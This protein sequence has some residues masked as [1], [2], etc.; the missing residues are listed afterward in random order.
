MTLQ[1]GVVIILLL[2]MGVPLGAYNMFKLFGTTGTFTYVI[3]YGLGNIAA[4]R[5]FRTTGRDESSLIKYVLFPV[6]ATAALL[7][8]RLQV[9]HTASCRTGSLRP[10]NPRRLSRSRSDMPALGTAAWAAGVDCARW[11]HGDSC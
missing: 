5:Y 1:F 6:V 11:R 10:G 2:A 4:W 9:L 3:I 8:H 7:L